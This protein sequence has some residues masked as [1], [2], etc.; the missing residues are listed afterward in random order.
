M[1]NPKKLFTILVLS[2]LFLLFPVLVHAQLGAIGG[3]GEGASATPVF[4]MTGEPLIAEGKG[5]I[6]AAYF[7]TR[8]TRSY[9][10]KLEKF[11]NVFG[12]ADPNRAI[13]VTQKLYLMAYGITDRFNVQVMVPYGTLRLRATSNTLTGESEEAEVHGIGNTSAALKYQFSQSPKLAFQFTWIGPSGFEPALTT[14]ATTLR[15]DL[16]GSMHTSAV[17]FHLQVGYAYVGEDRANRNLSDSAVV[18]LAIAKYLGGP[19]CTAVLELTGFRTGGVLDP[20]FDSPAQMALDLSPGL[21]VK[22]KDNFSIE[23]AVKFSLI[24]DLALG[25][26]TSYLF[27]AGY[28]F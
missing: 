25:Y 15:A 23:S 16:A 6:A 19:V 18:N 2:G 28:T 12:T 5:D 20:K 22:V 21:K 26:D 1:T 27:L 3:V 10:D 7:Y 24:N 13:E 8:I 17:D 14:D 9:G 4:T 11:S